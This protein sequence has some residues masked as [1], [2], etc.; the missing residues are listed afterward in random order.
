MVTSTPS[1]LSPVLNNGI[2]CR[3]C[4][5]QSL[6]NG[7]EAANRREDAAAPQSL[8]VKRDT[9]SHSFHTPL[10]NH[11]REQRGAQ[12]SAQLSH[13][14]ADTVV[15]RQ[16]LFWVEKRGKHVCSR[17]RTARGEEKGQVVDGEKNEGVPA[18]H[19]KGNRADQ[20]E[21]GEH[22]ETLG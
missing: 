4:H 15:K 22:E 20:E 13:A 6:G 14:R 10:A 8:R 21:R 18:A 1:G 3:V 9:H 11:R 5:K 7:D 12:R 19:V 16:V 2:S 17:P